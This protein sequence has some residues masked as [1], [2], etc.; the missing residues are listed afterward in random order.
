MKSIYIHQEVGY[1]SFRDA[2]WKPPVAQLLNSGLNQG[3]SQSDEMK[4]PVFF[5]FI[6]FS[7]VPG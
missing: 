1:R 2:I 7:H 6:I 5:H 3:A 4:K